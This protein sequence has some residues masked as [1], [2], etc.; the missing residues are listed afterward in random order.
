MSGRTPLT[1]GSLQPLSLCAAQTET[2]A[3]FLLP[4]VMRCERAE[5]RR[6]W[7]VLVPYC[8]SVRAL[9]PLSADNEMREA[10]KFLS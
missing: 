9:S 8:L 6:C 1:L 5:A 7:Q 10:S 3:P 2:V 4:L